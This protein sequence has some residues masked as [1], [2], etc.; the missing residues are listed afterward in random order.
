MTGLIGH[1]EAGNKPLSQ[2][3]EAKNG[4]PIKGLVN[5]HKGANYVRGQVAPDGLNR[6]N[7]GA[8]RIT[9]SRP[10]PH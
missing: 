1:Q 2:I 7:K 6:G 5:K 3:T 4:L 8:A 10:P 9:I